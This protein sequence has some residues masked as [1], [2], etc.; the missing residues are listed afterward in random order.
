MTNY[1][2]QKYSRTELNAA[3]KLLSTF[4]DAPTTEYSQAITIIDN[5]RAAHAYGLWQF[6]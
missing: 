2:V 1:A 4:G 6:V 3:G 5:W